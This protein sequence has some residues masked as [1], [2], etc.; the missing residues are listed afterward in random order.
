ME[1]LVFRLYAPIASWGDTAVGEMRPSRAEPG[2]SALLGLLAAALGIERH[3]EAAHQALAAGYGMAI[4]VLDEGRTLRDYHTTQA[5]SRAALK[6]RPHRTRRDELVVAKDDLNTIL[7]TRDYRQD[8]LI[9]VAV[10]AR[11]QAPHSLRDLATALTRP[12]YVLYLGRKSCP[13]AAPL[14]PLVQDAAHAK[15]ACEAYLAAL[16]AKVEPR[17]LS[18]W[19]RHAQPGLDAD[20]RARAIESLHWADGVDAGVQPTFSV[21]RKDRPLSRLRWQFG[22]R[23]EHIALLRGEG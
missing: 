13:L 1:F 9:V 8:S 17:S 21:P 14:W 4:A 20:G 10:Q 22:D 15:A 18:W 7:S 12:R 19:D 23:T 16:A 2:E 6:R 5:P 3:D 11:P